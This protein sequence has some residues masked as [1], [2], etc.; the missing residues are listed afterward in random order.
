MIDKQKVIYTYHSLR[1]AKLLARKQNV[2]TLCRIGYCYKLV[3]PVI[4]KIGYNSVWNYLKILDFYKVV[5]LYRRLKKRKDG[6]G[7]VVITILTRKESDRL[8]SYIWALYNKK[9]IDFVW[10]SKWIKLRRFR[11]QRMTR[12]ERT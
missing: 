6:F 9:I 3:I 2:I 8:W 10:D 5:K 11:K 1:R 12:N 7:I 4:E